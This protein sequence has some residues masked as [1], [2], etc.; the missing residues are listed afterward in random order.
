MLDALCLQCAFTACAQMSLTRLPARTHV[1][2]PMTVNAMT[3]G[4]TLGGMVVPMGL[5]AMTVVTEL[6]H[7]TRPRS[8]V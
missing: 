6:Q 3:E 2:G 4:S 1:G 8:Q 7:A 5:I